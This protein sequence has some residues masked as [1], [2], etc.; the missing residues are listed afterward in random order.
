[1]TAIRL[2]GRVTATIVQECVV[3]LDP[4]EQ[5]LD[6]NLEAVVPAGEFEIW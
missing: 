6:E 4:V 3:T 1:V 5:R 2:K